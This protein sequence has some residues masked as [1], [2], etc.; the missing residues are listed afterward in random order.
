MPDSGACP[1]EA[2]RPAQ[3]MKAALAKREAVQ[4][5]PARIPPPF[6]MPCMGPTRFELVIFTMSR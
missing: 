4:A 1:A 5:F 6:L 2:G 3:P